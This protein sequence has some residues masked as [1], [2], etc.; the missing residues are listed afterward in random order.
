M[1]D[2]RSKLCWIT[3]SFLKFFSV[4]CNFTQLNAIKKPIIFSSGTNLY[5]SITPFKCN[6]VFIVSR[7]LLYT[8]KKLL[9]KNKLNQINSA[10]LVSSK[11]ICLY[12]INIY[13]KLSKQSNFKKFNIF[14]SV[15]SDSKVLSYISSLI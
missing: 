9:I 10:I 14:F 12:L 13:L 7:N 11:Y 5:I 8:E 2:S 6:K 4:Q 1:L 15:H 3:Q